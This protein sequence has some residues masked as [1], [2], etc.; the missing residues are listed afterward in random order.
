AE[1]LSVSVSEAILTINVLP[2]TPYG[3][4]QVQFMSTDTNPFMSADGRYLLFEDGKTNVK[5]IIGAENPANNIRNNLLTQ[6]K[7]NVYNLERGTF[8]RDI[9]N[10]VSTGMLKANHD[11]GLTKNENYLSFDVLDERK[12]RGS[13]PF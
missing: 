13:G 6:L 8:I 4:Y 1:V 7:D 9:L 5:N 12:I 3:Q 11:I 10:Q 2:L